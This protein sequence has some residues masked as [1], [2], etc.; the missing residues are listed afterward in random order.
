MKKR[1]EVCFVNIL[2]VITAVFEDNIEVVLF[3]IT[4][5]AH[6]VPDTMNQGQN[7]LFK[8]PE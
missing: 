2:A 1:T 7:N 4:F 5:R 8:T 6:Y 3:T